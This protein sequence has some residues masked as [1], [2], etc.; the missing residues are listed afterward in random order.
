MPLDYSIWEKIVRN[1]MDTAP[2]RK[3]EARADFLKRLKEVATSLPKGCVKSSIA[4]MH[5]N[6]KALVAS[7][8]FTPKND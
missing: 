8:G 1:L 7:S 4:R 3:K 5:A 2:K 6:V